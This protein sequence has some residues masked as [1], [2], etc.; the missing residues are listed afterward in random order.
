MS[1]PEHHINCP[2]FYAF[3]MGDTATTA[4]V[5]DCVPCPECKGTGEYVYGHDGY[6]SITWECC[7]CIDCDGCGRLMRQQAKEIYG[8]I[9]GPEST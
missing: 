9:Y 2:A 8:P 6:G 4:P 5:C 3:E 7:E 1:N